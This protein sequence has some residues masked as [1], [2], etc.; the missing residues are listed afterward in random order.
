[1]AAGFN[2]L[3]GEPTQYDSIDELDDE[4]EV[5]LV[6]NSCVEIAFGNVLRGVSFLYTSQLN[7]TDFP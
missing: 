5:G 3:L 6:V 1:M 4:K 2:S 7:P